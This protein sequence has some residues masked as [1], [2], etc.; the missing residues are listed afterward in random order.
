MIDQLP[1]DSGILAAAPTRSDVLSQVQSACAHQFGLPITLL[2][3]NFSLIV[4]AA[5]KDNEVEEPRN[6]F[7][8]EELSRIIPDSDRIKRF[9][10]QVNE[11]AY[12]ASISFP[13]PI[14]RALRDYRL[15]SLY[16]VLSIKKALDSNPEKQSISISLAPFGK[17]VRFQLVLHRL[18]NSI[19][20]Y[21]P[22]FVEDT[23]DQGV[24]TKYA[25]AVRNSVD[26]LHLINSVWF[27][28]TVSPRS[29]HI[30]TSVY[31]A[32]YLEGL[33]FQRQKF[34]TSSLVDRTKRASYILNSISNFETFGFVDHVT[35]T[36]FSKAVA[37][38]DVVRKSGAPFSF[39]FKYFIDASGPRSGSLSVIP[40]SGRAFEF[41]MSAE[42]PTEA[43]EYR[44]NIERSFDNWTI[45]IQE[46]AHQLRHWLEHSMSA[47]D[48]EWYSAIGRDFKLRLTR[49]L[50]FLFNSAECSIYTPLHDA[51]HTVTQ[52]A[53]FSR[54]RVP[55]ERTEVMRRHIESLSKTRMR[56]RSISLR[57][58]DYDSECYC[59]FFDYE[60][61]T[62]FPHSQPISFPIELL[63][64]S[65]GKSVL[66]V[67][68]KMH[69]LTLGVLE[70]V[71]DRPHSYPE[72][73]RVKVGQVMEILAVAL[74]EHELFS[75]M[76]QFNGVSVGGVLSG[77]DSKRDLGPILRRIFFCESVAIL[78]E[79]KTSDNAFNIFLEFGRDDL[80]AQ[81]R[82]STARASAY[83]A[84]Y[85]AFLATNSES[86]VSEI[87]TPEFDKL[88]GRVNGRKYFTERSG[89]FLCLFRLRWSTADQEVRP[90]VLILT[91]R[92]RPGP[93]RRWLDVVAYAGRHLAT[94]TSILQSSEEWEA[95]LRSK[96]A[97]E[98]TR[99]ADT[100]AATVTKLS[101][102]H[103]PRIGSE[104]APEWSLSTMVT[105][106]R[107]SL[108]TL[109]THVN[110]LT[111]RR[112][113]SDYD[114]DPRLY[115]AEQVRKKWIAA[116]ESQKGSLRTAYN[117]AF[118]GQSAEFTRVGIKFP[119]YPMADRHV[120]MD[121]WS[122][123]EVV[124]TL[125]SNILK[126]GKNGTEIVISE[127]ST[128]VFGL[129]ISN[130]GL[131][132]D[133]YELD[134]IFDDGTR[135]S[136]A[137]ALLPNDGH[138]YGLWYVQQLLR[139]WGMG[140]RHSQTSLEHD[141]DSNYAW[142]HFTLLFPK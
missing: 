10:Y 93:S 31:D 85:H 59:Q 123:H 135:G 90:G 128:S 49:F 51:S 45:F 70:L 91:Y 103:L 37:A 94:L 12:S 122:L 101:K 124:Q 66:A 100:M 142:Q 35:P 42:A 8:L 44:E 127:A 22:V 17:H 50:A 105:D 73:V 46:S 88:F 28:N 53:S 102:F 83:F 34:T 72:I 2:S 1:L 78:R 79:S 96:V 132:L 20:C 56:R 125:V 60:L 114:G 109:N 119:K 86:W 138:G 19:A 141:G 15:F 62:S 29:D 21:G 27:D 11:K 13:H 99:V 111:S 116:G 80:A 137:S 139:I 67:P 54:Y 16:E 71:S 14:H 136:R 121:D 130:I 140:I 40:G 38:A 87:G 82:E 107:R 129:R 112:N 69:G 30:R 84:P 63:D 108:R 110:V 76:D 120:L 97:H 126:Y 115:S 5:L 33:A 4:A 9:L 89:H 104:A 48:S 81:R 61:Q 74:F 92:R 32:E 36:F 43:V 118:H 3:A 25:G 26:Q 55:M 6:E 68:I 24:D 58:I 39:R 23:A 113:L 98:L 134:A 65:W 133:P 47:I 75:A 131:K 41:K 106:L 77:R 117:A 57:S 52:F 95:V 64:I 7:D 18:K